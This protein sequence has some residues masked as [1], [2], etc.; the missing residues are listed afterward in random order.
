MIR[1]S[2]FLIEAPLA[3]DGILINT[4]ES[5]YC[6]IRRTG[7]KLKRSLITSKKQQ[8]STALLK[9]Y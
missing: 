8:T 6:V 5:F 7:I 2:G 9:T 1:N 4:Q 3:A